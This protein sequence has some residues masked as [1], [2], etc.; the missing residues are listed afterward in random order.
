MNPSNKKKSEQLE[1]NFSTACNRL[2]RNMMFR[3]IQDAGK[4]ICYRCDEV[5]EKADD[6]S[7]DHKID[8]LNS[9]N[10]IDLFWDLDNI[11]FSHKSC[12]SCHSVKP[13]IAYGVTKLKNRTKPYQVRCWDGKKQALVGYFVTPE[14]AAKAYDEKVKELGLRGRPTNMAQ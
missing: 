9:K 13:T 14:E 8:W 10:P 1:M 5:I 7:L 11:S 12:N 3:L 4:N 6:F 2:R